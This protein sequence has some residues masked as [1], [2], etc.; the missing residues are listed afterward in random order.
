LVGLSGCSKKEA[1]SYPG[2]ADLAHAL[3]AN[4]VGCQRFEMTSSG[5]AE[6]SA[7]PLKKGAQPLVR[8]A[9]DCSHGTAKLLLFTF[10]S[11]AVRDRWLALGHLYGSTVVGPDWAVTTHNKDV[12]ANIADAIGGEVK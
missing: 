11:S 5:A 10:Q 7:T 2:V 3:K 8:Q 6:P 4:G 9:G 1:I 12:A